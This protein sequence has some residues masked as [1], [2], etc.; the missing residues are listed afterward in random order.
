MK[1]GSRSHCFQKLFKTI[2]LE[3]FAEFRYKGFQSHLNK[4]PILAYSSVILLKEYDIKEYLKSSSL[5]TRIILRSAQEEYVEYR[6]SIARHHK[7]Y[8]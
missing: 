2:I 4:I 8:P 6:N 7:V 3:K 1:S 5:F